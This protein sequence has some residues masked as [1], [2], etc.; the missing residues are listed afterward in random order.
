MSF[1]CCPSC[2][3]FSLGLGENIG[4][5]GAQFLPEPD[6]NLLSVGEGDAGSRDLSAFGRTFAVV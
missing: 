6:F 1:R 2:V 3:C 4:V 5:G